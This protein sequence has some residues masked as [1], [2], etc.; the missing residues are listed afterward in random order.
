[1]IGF[2][3]LFFIII[4]LYVNKCPLEALANSSAYKKQGRQ[5]LEGLN[6]YNV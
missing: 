4:G 3:V 5:S 6:L 2:Y 1:M